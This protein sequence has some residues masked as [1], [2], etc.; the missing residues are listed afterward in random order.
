MHGEGTILLDDV[1]I[2]TEHKMNFRCSCGNHF[3]TTFNKFKSRN[4]IKCNECTNTVRWNFERVEKLFKKKGLTPLF[5]KVGGA[6]KN[7]KAKTREGYIVQISPD[8]LN[9]GKT[10]DVF[11]KFNPYTIDNIKLKIYETGYELISDEYK[12]NYTKLK[13]RCNKG[14]I[15]EMNWADFDSGRRCAKCSKRYKRTN[16]EF[17]EEVF[18]LVGIEYEF[19]EEFKG[20][21]EKIDV[22]HNKCGH[23]YK[24][25]PYKFIYNDRRCPKCNESKG[26]KRI[27]QFLISKNIKYKQEYSFKDCKYVLPLRFD[28]A[29]FNKNKLS[30]LIE[31]D[32]K[33]HFRPCD[34]YGGEKSFKET[35]LRD[36]IKN[37]YCKKNNIKL[38]RIPYKQF[39]NIEKI[40]SAHL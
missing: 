38:I 39:D 11:S 13:W 32:G 6:K 34:Y 2:N 31:F 35:K 3:I 25:T 33:Q 17:V 21:D 1:Y 40:L 28:F 8:K 12:N 7:L 22:I 10:P 5:D 19:L 37:E 14:H 29:V 23:I 9:Q 16:D 36:S 24:V 27:E 20:V 15:F 26:E 30:F 18:K 4:K